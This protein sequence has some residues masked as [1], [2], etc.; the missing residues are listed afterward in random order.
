M[1]LAPGFQPFDPA[2]TEIYGYGEYPDV[3]TSTYF[4]RILATAGPTAGKLV[5]PSD[6]KPVARIAFLQCVGS[7]DHNTCSNEYCSSICCM[8]A[9]KEA[10]VAKES[11][12]ELDAAIFFTDLRAHG[13]G[14][15]TFYQ[16]AADQS[17]V[18]FIRSRIHGVEPHGTDGE[19]KIHYVNDQGR[20][21][22]EYFDLVVLSVGLVI[23]ESLHKLAEKI[24]INLTA[25]GFAATSSFMPVLSSAQ[26][27]FVC[28]AFAG[29]KDIP[30]TIAEGS[31]A[32]S[33][34]AE[35][36]ASGRHSTTCEQTFPDE[37][38][39]AGEE[40]RTGVFI[41]HCG[42]NIA[43]VVDIA[44]AAEYAAK[45]P[46]VVH[47][48]D[49]LFACSPDTQDLL[50]R[51]IRDKQ[52]NRIVIAACTPRTHEALFQKTL[53]TAG[54]NEYLLKMA[55]IRNQ[56][57]WV[58]RDNPG[59]ATL[60]AQE[61]IRMA[62][63]G[64][65]PQRPLQHQVVAITPTALVIGGGLTGMTAALA[66]ADQGFKVYLVEQSGEL[67]GYAGLL[68]RTWNGEDIGLS[69]A[70]IIEKVG[71]HPD[72]EVLM[73]ARVIASEGHVGNFTTTILA[74]N[75][76]Q[77]KISHGAAI[78]AIG[79]KRSRP[80]QYGYGR[81]ARV[82]T[83]L[84]FDKLY[85]FGD[86]RVKKGSSFV[87]IQCVGS[88]D[89]DHPYCSKVCCTHSVQSAIRMKHENPHRDVYILYRDMR[90]YGQ[91]EALYTE[92]RRLGV[93]FINYEV[94]G[95]PEVSR[96]GDDSLQVEVWDHIL[97]QP[98][99]IKAD[100]VILATAILPNQEAK[101][102]ADLFKIP[103]DSDGFFQEAHAKMRPVDCTRQGLF[104][105]GLAHS[106]KP[107]EESITQALAAAARAA[108]FLARDTVSLSGIRAEVHAD[109]C[110]GCALCID[111]CPYHAI[112]LIEAA[113]SDQDREPALS[114]AINQ[115]LCT[116]CGICQGTCPKRGVSIAGFSFE[117]I[118]N[119]VT[120]ALAV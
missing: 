57:S 68:G 88:R 55:N 85:Q 62:V 3:I 104:I 87:F 49:N 63:A 71:E 50:V 61:L 108:T 90:T 91:R 19:L 45:L 92:A 113:D 42:S 74:E 31:A 56:D 75:R 83:A 11:N 36:L 34:A 118:T 8:A 98:L 81:L 35:L 116:G 25:N 10:V 51:R 99:R 12:P 40:P 110:D 89:Q 4:E 69:L 101:Q 112:T 95:K 64:G 46:S 65:L 9:V 54:I 58:H 5:R 111:V 102:L 80:R 21:V 15:D 100:M 6:G 27:V 28:G 120:A 43:G 70:R 59:Q 2:G 24:N 39:T 23:P 33:G 117:Q 115:T 96:N 105:A 60:K 47:V 16:R 29:P 79:G 32:A 103:L 93:V 97:H 18:R 7:R 13:K 78:V 14:C 86:V 106:P 67:G 82:V 26:G 44:A 52:L 119:Q 48:E 84:E 94:H 73:H 53:K 66:L 17:G 72:I 30:L 37:R 20:Q 1:I 41:C 76:V 114:I 77:R 107:V 38:D 109:K 22:N